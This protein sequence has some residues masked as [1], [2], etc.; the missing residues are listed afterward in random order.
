[1]QLF[2]DRMVYSCYHIQEKQK[3]SAFTRGTGRSSI[4]MHT[5]FCEMVS[6]QDWAGHIQA[7][8]W[9]A[10]A[11]TCIFFAFSW[12][13]FWNF[14]HQLSWNFLKEQFNLK[15]LFYHVSFC[16]RAINESLSA[17][18]FFPILHQFFK[19]LSFRCK[20]YL[21]SFCSEM[22]KS[23]SIKLSFFLCLLLYVFYNT[24]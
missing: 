20:T 12:I 8:Q 9:A 17:S 21:A 2:Q 23:K 5:D 18:T 7:A 24:Y 16:F 15:V 3:K 22:L 11:V 10:V 13:G 14:S 4:R 1:M 6:R 19:L